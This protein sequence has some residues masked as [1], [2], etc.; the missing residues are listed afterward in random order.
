MTRS[1][2]KVAEFLRDLGFSQELAWS[3]AV[4]HKYGWVDTSKS[5]DIMKPAMYYYW[6]VKVSELSADER[7]RLMVGKISLKDLKN[8]PEYEGLVEEDRLT[9][10]IGL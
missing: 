6:L 3:R 2:R 4:R 1:E 7:L 10:M 5:G 9:E 8:Y